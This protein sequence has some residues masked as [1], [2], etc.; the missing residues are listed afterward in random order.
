MSSN[1]RDEPSPEGRFD[2]LMP[3]HVPANK[4]ADVLGSTTGL[5][6]PPWSRQPHNTFGKLPTDSQSFFHRDGVGTDLP[7]T[8][9][10][11]LYSFFFII[12]RPPRSTLFPY[13]TLFR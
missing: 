1:N 8:L 11:H 10:I 12:R 3:V 7:C 2:P 4:D 6:T 13:T 5:A 9:C